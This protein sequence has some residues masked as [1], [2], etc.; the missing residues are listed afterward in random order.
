MQDPTGARAQQ[1]CSLLTWG[2]HGDVAPPQPA[3]VLAQGSAPD[4]HV[5]LQPFH[6]GPDGGDHGVD[7]HGDLPGGGQDQDLRGDLSK[8]WILI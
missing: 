2:A 8:I 7:L 4:E 3:P 6:L 1:S 5:A